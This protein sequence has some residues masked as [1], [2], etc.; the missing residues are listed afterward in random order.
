VAEQLVARLV[1]ERVVDALEAVDVDEQRRDGRLVALR[2]QERLL[3]TVE[4]QRAVGQAGERVVRG[5]ERE[6]RVG[7]HAL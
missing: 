1:A 3:D 5:H 7:A 4:D 6:L 2:A